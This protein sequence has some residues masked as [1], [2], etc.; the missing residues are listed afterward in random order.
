[1]YA[2]NRAAEALADGRL[3]DAYAWA[4]ESAAQGPGVHGAY[5]TLGVVYLRH[6]DLAEAE[7]VVR[8]RPRRRRRRTRARSPTSP[9]RYERQGRSG[10]RAA[11]AHAA[12]GAR[13]VPAVPLL[14]ARHGRGAARRLAHR[15]RAV[16]ARGR[17]R[18]HLPRVPLLARRRR[19]AARRR[20]GGAPPPGAGDRQQPD[21]RPARPLRRQAR[22]GCR[23]IAASS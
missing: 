6:G 16:R 17:A 1:M 3:D 11:D 14:P 5:N 22:S 4:A 13:A 15:A 20:G 21:A 7:R 12:R 2:N 19:L 23:G 10:R 9:S 8:A 18:R